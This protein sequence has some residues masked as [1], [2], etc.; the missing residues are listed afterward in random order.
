MQGVGVR[1]AASPEADSVKLTCF[2]LF[3]K[4]GK[5]VESF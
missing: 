5:E 4:F 2:A 1:N 3:S